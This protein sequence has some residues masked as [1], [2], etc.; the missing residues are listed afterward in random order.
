MGEG[1]PE[2]VGSVR[3]HAKK[4]PEALNSTPGGLKPLTEVPG[5]S[6]P[7]ASP[8]ESKEVQ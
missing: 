8:T 7:E 4:S 2:G 6:V 5:E 3:Q 1:L